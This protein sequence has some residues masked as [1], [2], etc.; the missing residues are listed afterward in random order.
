MT[1]AAGPTAQLPA[2]APGASH[3]CHL[4]QY[5][6]ILRRVCRRAA[7]YMGSR[8]SLAFC[9]YMHAILQVSGTTIRYAGLV[10]WRL[11]LVSMSQRCTNKAGAS[12]STV[13]AKCLLHN[14]MDIVNRHVA[15]HHYRSRVTRRCMGW[16]LKPFTC[17]SKFCQNTLPVETRRCSKLPCLQHAYQ[18][19]YQAI[20]LTSKVPT[21]AGCQRAAQHAA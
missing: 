8:T 13:D 12:L 11:G 17:T 20:S 9:M 16:V 7:G 5:E 4:S 21:V 1:S 15:N 3:T 10:P 6:N 18:Q 14:P 19:L 2:P